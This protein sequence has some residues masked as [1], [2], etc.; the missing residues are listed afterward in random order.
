[1]RVAEE[2]GIALPKNL[3]DLIYSFRYRTNLPAAIQE[4][5][6]TG[7]AWII[8]PAGRARYCFVRIIDQPI[9]PNEMLAET[10]IPDAT[11]GII[12]K[13][14]L[15][16]EQVLLA[17]LRYNRLI[18]I[19]TG[20]TCCSLQNHLRTTVP[21]LGQVE[22]DEVYIGIDRRGAHHVFP[23]QAK[24][25][26]DKINIVQIEQ[27]FALCA[28]KFPALICRPI[29]AQFIHG[30]LIVLFDFEESSGGLA[31]S[32]EKHYRLVSPNDLT[33]TE[34]ATYALRTL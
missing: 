24:G 25:G 15:S 12:T 32:S 22:T 21:G 31:V 34:L 11:P 16:D 7:E 30:D 17:K 6:P 10:K 18:D 29:A 14:A 5:T 3:G 19:F 8:R 26:R 28:H 27:D 33:M 23:V 1:V 13:Y 9:T 20:V 4:R 2:L